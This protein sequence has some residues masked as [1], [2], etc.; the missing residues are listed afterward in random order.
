MRDVHFPIPGTHHLKFL[1]HSFS[2]L[3][4]NIFLIQEEFPRER[5][6]YHAAQTERIPNM[7]HRENIIDSL[8]S[9]HH[10]GE[11]GGFGPR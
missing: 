5:S 2:T 6:A 1:N 11:I 10:F 8:S 3:F 7:T 9:A 4:E